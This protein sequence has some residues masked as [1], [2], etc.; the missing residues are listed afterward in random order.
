MGPAKR[1]HPNLERKYRWLGLLLLA[2]VFPSA[3]A[4]AAVCPADLTARVEAIAAQP[5]LRPA[6]LGVRVETETGELVYERDS[7]RYFVPASNV[8]LFTTAATLQFLGPDFRIRTSIYGS[9]NDLGLTTLR[10]FGR[11]DP[12]LSDTQLAELARQLRQQGVQRVA[13]LVADDSYFPGQATNPNWEW[14]DVQAGYGA[15][16]NSL[17]VNRNALGLSLVPQAIGQPLQVVWDDPPLAAQ[18][19]IENNSVTVAAGQPEY[20]EVGRDLGQPVLQV[21][22]QLVAGSAADTAAIAVP[23]PSQYFL[24]RLQA[25]L[26]AEQISV[27]RTSAI[28]TP[29]PNSLPELAFVE[30]APLRELLIPTNRSSNNLYA[31]ALLKTLGMRASQGDEA[32]E[33]GIAALQAV[34]EPLGVDPTAYVLADGSGLSRHNLTTPTAL[35]QVLQVMNRSNEAETYRNSLATA[36]V[37]GTLRNRLQGT[38]AAGRL[39]GKTG[40]ISRNAALSGYLDPPSYEPLVLSILLNNV[41]QPGRVLR[42]AIDEIVAL[43]AALQ[44]C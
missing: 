15:P 23:N 5:A 41:D 34:L 7:D 28:S 9:T 6:R 43:L 3:P 18:W 22:G 38:A 32:T 37:N 30:S 36:G 14:E 4:I 12:S 29:T 17:I 21:R 26:A 8:K 11:G 42:Q 10:V 24:D 35:V 13:S 33:L 44:P 39:Q 19:Q 16:V 27:A 40:S 31:E 2:S 25:A 1:A 20:T